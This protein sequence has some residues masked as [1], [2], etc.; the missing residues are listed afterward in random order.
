MVG[1]YTQAR[2]PGEPKRL[3][4]TNPTRSIEDVTTEEVMALTNAPSAAS[5]SSPFS[6]PGAAPILFCALLSIPPL[7][8]QSLDSATPA[9]PAVDP[10]L[11]AR[12][13]DLLYARDIA[14]L[15]GKGALNANKAEVDALRRAVQPLIVGATK[16]NP[17]T[18]TWS[19]AVNVESRDDAVASCLPGGKIM[20]STGFLSRYG[21]TVPEQTAIVAHVISHAL[22]RDDADETAARFVK[23]GGV[24][25]ADPNRTV[26]KLAEVLAGVMAT[27]PHDAVTERATDAESLKLMAQSG[28]DPRPAADAWRKIILGGAGAPPAFSAL[29]PAWPTRVAELEAEMPAMVAHYERVLR[30]QPAPPATPLPVPPGARR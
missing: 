6:R 30:E 10:A 4:R 8:A 17:E 7:F 25:G 1:L 3:T 12:A 18:K 5:L 23:E 15:R 14:R 28:V 26:L 11:I 29:H 16:L 13:A 9:A 19:W 2:G 24:V 27:A 20:V 22:A 21:L